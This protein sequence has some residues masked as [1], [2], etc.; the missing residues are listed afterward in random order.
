MFATP[1]KAEKPKTRTIYCVEE[2]KQNEELS[3][4]PKL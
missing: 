3:E 1:Y 4:M 2:T